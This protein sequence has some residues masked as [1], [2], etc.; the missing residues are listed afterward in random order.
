ML[1][2]ASLGWQLPA[3]VT[4]PPKGQRE[5]TTA[6]KRIPITVNHVACDILLPLDCFFQYDVDIRVEKS[7]K[8]GQRTQ[9]GAD[10]SN[11]ANQMGG[12]NVGYRGNPARK[13]LSNLTLVLLHVYRVF[14]S[15]ARRFAPCMHRTF[16]FQK[17]KELIPFKF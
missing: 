1:R 17:S 9:P 15:R 2:A 12:L 3:G 16:D 5:G 7:K 8:V 6:R 14:D 13:L 4:Q 11:L 10:A